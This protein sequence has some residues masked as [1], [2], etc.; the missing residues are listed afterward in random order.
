M[1]LFQL[2][3]DNETKTLY[4][5]KLCKII[6]FYIDVELFSVGIGKDNSEFITNRISSTIDSY[7]NEQENILKIF[8]AS[9]QIRKGK[10]IMKF[11]DIILALFM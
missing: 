5:Q 1:N 2:T 3:D 8:R 10:Q 4:K 11:K 6:S 7:N 9:L